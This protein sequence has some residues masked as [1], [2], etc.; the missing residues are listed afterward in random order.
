MCV[1]V[2]VCSWVYVFVFVCMCFCEC[3]LFPNLWLWLFGCVCVC[4]CI[5]L[6]SVFVYIYCMCLYMF[7]LCV[8]E[9]IVAAGPEWPSVAAASS[10]LHHPLYSPLPAWQCSAGW[11]A[12]KD[13]GG[14][15]VFLFDNE[16]L[17]VLYCGW[18]NGWASFLTDIV[19]SFIHFYTLSGGGMYWYLC[20]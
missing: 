10:L 16:C 3:V 19:L 2:C 4:V 14:V 20:Q 8:L 18:G 11:S 5:Y 7:L 6:L 15:S 17:S 12:G 9:A 13:R 1:F